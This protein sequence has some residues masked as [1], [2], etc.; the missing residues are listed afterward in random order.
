M[1]TALP[2]GQ[3]ATIAHAGHLAAME[4]PAEVAAVLL[5]FLAGP[6]GVRRSGTG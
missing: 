4:A 1:V 5:Q 6:A 3:L 2:D